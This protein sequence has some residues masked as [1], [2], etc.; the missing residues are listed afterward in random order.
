M[1][2]PFETKYAET[3]VRDAANT[4]NITDSVWC[5][6]KICFECTLPYANHEEDGAFEEEFCYEIWA[7]ACLYDNM[8]NGTEYAYLCIGYEE[9]FDNAVKRLKTD[10][11]KKKFLS[12][13]PVYDLSKILQNAVYALNVIMGI[14]ADS[15][16]AES[17]K[18][19]GLSKEFENEITGLRNRLESHI[20]K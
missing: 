18:A 14:N 11:S 9:I 13:K 16:L 15:E 8:L 1:I 19:A 17:M 12:R 6:D 10:I 3:L 20:N 2:T 7:S 4:D 5:T